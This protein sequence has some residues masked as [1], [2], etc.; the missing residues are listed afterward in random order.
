MDIPPAPETKWIV[1]GGS[2]SGNLAAWMRY[3]YPDIVF[4]AV[5]SSAPVEMRYNFH[6]YFETIRRYAPKHCVSS[7]QQV[8]RYVDHILFSPFSESKQ[9]MKETF[10][11]Q[12]LEH[13]DDF[14]ES[15]LY[16]SIYHP[17]LLMLS[18]CSPIL[19]TWT[20]ARNDTNRESIC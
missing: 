14:A 19:P 12:D 17:L 10:G 13:D 15:E 3:R 16:N 18:R 11:L 6:Q 1:Y 20:M 9:R 4:A 2:Y 8:V 5:P 7:I